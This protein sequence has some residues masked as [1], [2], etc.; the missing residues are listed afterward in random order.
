MFA[1]FCGF[2][3][4]DLA[5]GVT[6][7]EEAGEAAAFGFEGVDR[8]GV[9]ITSAGVG[10]VVLATAQGTFVPCIDQ[11]KNQRSLYADARM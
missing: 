5:G 3:W 1:V 11:I 8:E 9:V 4:N 10:N 7:A 2:E 6:E